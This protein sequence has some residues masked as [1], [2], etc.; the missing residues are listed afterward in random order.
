MQIQTQVIQILQMY[1]G[2]SRLSFI[3]IWPNFTSVCMELNPNQTLCTQ[4]STV[5]FIKILS[6]LTVVFMYVSSDK[7]PSKY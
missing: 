5:D 7:I 4:I 2:E 1:V 3:Q 6:S